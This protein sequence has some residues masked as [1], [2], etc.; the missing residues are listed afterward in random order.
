MP[1]MDGGELGRRIIGDPHLSSTRPILL[2]T[3]DN[4]GD[5]RRFAAQGFAGYLSKP[6][7][8][9][10]LLSSLERVLL[11]EAQVWHL[12]TQ[13]IVTNHRSP[14]PAKSGR[15]A[16]KV[17]L[18][19]DNAVNQKVALRFL[20]RMG[21]AVTVAANGEEG[22]RAWQH[23]EFNLVLMDVQMPVMDGYTASRQIRSLETRRARIP[24]VALTANAM[25]GQLEKCLAAGMDALLTKPLDV[26]RLEEAL[27][28]F[29]MARAPASPIDFQQLRELTEGDDA[30]AQDLV[31]SYLRSSAELSTQ[32]DAC[33]A[34]NDR[35]Q[36]V[37]AVHQLAG[38][39]AYIH[40]APLCAL[41]STLEMAAAGATA[42]SLAALVDR[43]HAELARVRDT[44]SAAGSVGS[45]TPLVNRL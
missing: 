33:V 30:F 36:L 3:M 13:P 8:M 32:I 40:A 43:V 16:G 1:D 35:R 39:S 45:A 21:C 19:E 18:V 20:E 15:F 28:R 2:T 5:V 38:A 11:R 25:A 6:V 12:Q 23:G 34:L 7:R 37:R 26:E 4:Q 9:R 10:D 41:C 44:L 29:G 27:E 17:L 42:G 24:I 14:H 22:V 31:Q